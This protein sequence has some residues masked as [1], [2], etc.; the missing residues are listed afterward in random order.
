MKKRL[1]SVLL[2]VCICLS[3]AACTLPF[4]NKDSTFSIQ[5]I[6][7][8]QGDAALVEC[9]G[10]YMLIDGGPENHGKDVYNVLVERGVNRLNIL[11]ISHLDEDH[12]GG[13]IKAF[14]YINRVNLTI[15]NSKNGTSKTF[16]NLEPILLDCSKKTKIPAVGETYMLGSATVEV[17]D[18]SSK[19][20]N[21]SLVLLITYQDTRFLFT[22]DIEAKAQQRLAEK[23]RSDK[24]AVDGNFKIDLIKMPH[25]GAYNDIYGFQ[26]SNLNGLIYSI[27]P[28]ESPIYAVIS[29]GEGNKYGHPHEDTVKIL[30]QAKAIVY[31][32]DKCGDIT[33]K[34]NGKDLSFE[35]EKQY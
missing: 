15:C 33:V 11:A 27:K 23:I 32:T 14:E 20:E 18:V 12:I 31:R 10:Q 34:S 35:T 21:D 16:N 1:I 8:G 24:R 4:N 29:V 25:H 2:L 9:D 19:E 5:F 13:L 6:D 17:I 28:K 30:E 26:D 3:L 7:V 22:G